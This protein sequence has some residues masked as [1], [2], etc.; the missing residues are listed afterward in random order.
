MHRKLIRLILRELRELGLQARTALYAVVAIAG[1]AALGLVVSDTA[2]L[3]DDLLGAVIE[4]LA[5]IDDVLRD[6]LAKAE[7]IE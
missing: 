6:L 4:Y 7:A 3:T 5:D 1:L 2:G